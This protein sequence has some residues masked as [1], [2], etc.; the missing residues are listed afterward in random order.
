MEA[1]VAQIFRDAW[2]RRDGKVVP[3]PED[4]ALGNEGVN[5]EATVLYA[6]LRGSTALV[7]VMPATF[8]G[9][10]YKTFLVCAARIVKHHG[11]VI[12][13]YDGDRIMGV[14]IGDAKNTSAASAALRIHWAVRDIVQP[15]LEGIYGAGIYTLD[16]TVGVD[17]SSIMAARIGVRRDNDI[18]WIGRAANHAAKLTE[19]R[20]YASFITGEVYDQ[21]HAD[22]KLSDEGWDMWTALQW[23]EHKR[24]IYGS[25]WKW[26][27]A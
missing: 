5:L 25:N 9:E 18:V 24:R 10:V 13:S 8:S 14:F 3:A 21:L 1:E 6:D 26:T 17:T 23:P 19:Q 7:D 22:A 2:T 27:L 11:G 4:I 20:G 15:K 12:T 16:H